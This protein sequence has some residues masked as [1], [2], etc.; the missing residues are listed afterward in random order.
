[1]PGLPLWATG[2]R[3]MG[4]GRPVGVSQGVNIL[5]PL[6]EAQETALPPALRPPT[7]EWMQAENIPELP[8]HCGPG[9]GPALV[10]GNAEILYFTA[11]IS[12]PS[13][14][15]PPFKLEKRADSRS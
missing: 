5:C 2:T 7:G 15:P 12:R 8:C 13:V 14:C 10:R 3:R 9:L 4:L 1:M 11:H 6:E